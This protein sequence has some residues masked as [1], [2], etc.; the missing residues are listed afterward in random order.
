MSHRSCLVTLTV[1]AACHMPTDRF[2]GFDAGTDASGSD[3]GG[4]GSDTG[5]SGICPNLH[6]TL[7]STPSTGKTPYAVAV[8]NVDGD[9]MPDL[10]VANRGD[11][12]VSVLINQAQGTSWSRSNYSTCMQAPCVPLGLLVAPIDPGMSPD[13]VVANAVS[14]TGAVKG[15]VG[16]LLNNGDGTF[17]GP[18]VYSSTLGNPRSVA[19]PDLD[20]ARGRD[21]VI[22]EFDSKGNIGVMMNTGNKGAL[23]PEVGSLAAFRGGAFAVAV[24]DLDLPSGT[25]DVVVVDRDDSAVSVLLGV[26]DGS[27]RES[28]TYPVTG[29]QPVALAI[30]Q[31]NANQDNAPDI[32]VANSNDGTVS[33]LLNDGQGGFPMDKTKVG[34]YMTGTSP[35]SVVAVDVNGDHLV[36]LVV[37]NHDDNT[38]SVLLGNGDGTFAQPAKPVPSGGTGPQ[39]VAVADVNDD[40]QMDIVVANSGS[41]ALS[42]LLGSCAP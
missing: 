27:F 32:V 30:A 26:G 31:L 39:S 20:D 11:D 18:T 36:D 38:L 14:M 42:V 35:Q 23:A 3:T 5:L 4:P 24:A 13:I 6:F 33:V 34:H 40:G 9:N 28:T 7:S 10:V 8:A 21:L 29:T 41:D 25:P 16:I 37:A 2:Y 12:T 22:A 17:Q 15:S 1:V 19:A